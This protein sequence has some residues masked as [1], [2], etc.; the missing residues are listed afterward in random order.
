MSTPS[1]TNLVP[2]L[3]TPAPAPDEAGPHATAGGAEPRAP[4]DPV[5]AADVDS[6]EDPVRTYLREMGA[7]PLLTGADERRLARQLEESTHLRRLARD[8]TA[9]TGRVADPAALLALLRDELAT[10]RPVLAATER[11]LVFIA[12]LRPAG[13]DEQLRV[14]A[15]RSLDPELPPFRLALFAQEVL[16][17]TRTGTG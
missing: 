5:E 16:A 2:P 6:A 17:G 8:H 10:L 12:A 1:P 4:T 11:Y 15:A 13:A 7:I 14:D 9:A 3:L